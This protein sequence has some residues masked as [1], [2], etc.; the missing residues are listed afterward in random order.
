MS[1]APSNG[2]PPAPASPPELRAA[3]EKGD[4]SEPDLWNGWKD[5]AK[6]PEP[7]STHVALGDHGQDTV[8]SG[9][10]PLA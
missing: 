9:A 10:G 6:H 7:L 8:L 3:F 4:R 2:V 1:G 5:M